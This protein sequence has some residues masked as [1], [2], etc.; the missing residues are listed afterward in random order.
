MAESIARRHRTA[1]V[2]EELLEELAAAYRVLVAHSTEVASFIRSQQTNRVLLS[3][4][5]LLDATG[6]WEPPT[7]FV[8]PYSAIKVY[9][10]TA[11]TYF[12]TNEQTG[13]F[14]PPTTAPA[15]GN[16]WQ[17]VQRVDGLTSR[18][19]PLAGVR[20][21]ITGPANG[22]VSLA[23]YSSLESAEATAS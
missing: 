2:S 1:P 17:G 21:S 7:G 15:G 4:L 10:H 12:V 11:G 13:L 23:V 18:S 8:V 9:A 5:V 19:F 16:A 3:G 20:L 22:F 6:Y 14:A